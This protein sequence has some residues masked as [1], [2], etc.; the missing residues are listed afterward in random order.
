VKLED[1]IER[2]DEISKIYIYDDNAHVAEDSLH[3]AVLSSIAD[4][5]CETPAECAKA[6]LTTLVIDFA[7][8]YS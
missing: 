3:V 5:T 1:V 7:R 4:G 6:A 2:V 8:W